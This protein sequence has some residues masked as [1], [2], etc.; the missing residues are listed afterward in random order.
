[1]RPDLVAE[2]NRHTAVDRSGIYRH[3]VRFKRVRL[4]VTIEDVPPFAQ[5]PGV[6]D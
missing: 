6:V 4:D 3:P 2:I 1:M 5:G